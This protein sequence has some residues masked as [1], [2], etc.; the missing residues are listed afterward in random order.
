MTALVVDPITSSIVYA[1]TGSGVFKT[2]DGALSWA[3]ISKGLPSQITSLAVDPQHP[4]TVYF[5]ASGDYFGSRDYRS[6]DGGRAWTQM[7]PIVTGS[8]FGFPIP[9]T[10]LT[11]DPRSSNTLYA[12]ASVPAYPTHPEIGGA[13]VIYKSLDAGQ[14]WQKV[15]EVQSGGIASVLVDR[16][17]SSIVY[18]LISYRIYKSVDAGVTWNPANPAGVTYVSSL[19]QS[20]AGP[21]L[22]YAATSGNGVY[23]SPDGG[24]TWEAVNNGLTGDALA[25]SSVAAAGVSIVYASTGAGVFRSDDGGSSWRLMSPDRRSVLTVD[26]VQTSTLYGFDNYLASTGIF[27]GVSKSTDSG[28]TWS[29][30]NAGLNALGFSA[31]VVDPSSPATIYAGAFRRVSKSIDRGATWETHELGPPGYLLYVTDLVVDPFNSQTIYAATTGGV[32]RSSDGGSQW[33]SISGNLIPGVD[34]YINSLAV[35]SRVPERLFAGTGYGKLM[36]TDDGGATWIAIGP[37]ASDDGNSVVALDPARPGLVYFGSGDGLF[38]SEDSGAT[39]QPTSIEDTV[40]ALAI[41]PTVSDRVY[42][43]SRS[44]LFRSDDAGLHWKSIS[45]MLTSSI[46]I[47]PSHPSEI[48]VSNLGVQRSL[49]GGGT[50]TTE[51]NGLAVGELMTGGVGD[52]AWD[53]PGTHLYGA[54]TGVFEFEPANVVTI[55]AVSSLHGAPPTYFHSDV[56]VFNTSFQEPTRVTAKYRCLASACPEQTRTFMVPPRALSSYDDIVV[57]LFQQPET[58]GAVELASDQPLIVTSRLYTPARPSPTL[59]MF[60]PGLRAE[61]G[62]PKS[63][64]TS[65]SHSSQ[66]ALGSRTNIGV[67]NPSESSQT[68]RL[69]FRDTAGTDFGQIERTVG[70]GQLI[71]MNDPEIFSQLG[72][73]FDVPDFSCLVEGAAEQ[74]LFTYAAVIDN[75]SQDP[76]FVVGRSA[77][78]F[79]TT[80]ATLPA[81][82]SLHGA[83]GTFFHSDVS[84]FNPSTT[85]NLSIAARYRCGLGACTV[86]EKAFA[87]G[88][89][90][91]RKFNDFVGEFLQVPE[92]GGAVVFEAFNPPLAGLVVTSRLFTPT[93][94]DPTV[95]MFVPGLTPGEATVDAVLTSLASSSIPGK[96]FRTNVGAFNSSDASQTLSFFL[97]DA[98]GTALG[99]TSRVLPAGGAVQVNDIFRAVGA[100]GEIA[101]AYCL[102]RGDGQSPFFAYAAIIDNQTQD[103]IFVP[104]QSDLEVPRPPE[105]TH[106]D[107]SE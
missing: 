94:P 73:A 74:S 16:A 27:D 62:F 77:G 72:I 98:S 102:V 80:S 39:W 54:G 33:V 3:A 68:V 14:S 89:L 75:Q 22:L 88:P 13:A 107:R 17:S 93:R 50:W 26:P 45:A 70:P 65:L 47:R 99:R 41:D 36:R 105:L 79:T 48:R 69:S 23:R 86:S 11:V 57:T 28:A 87:V 66:Q 100:A 24:T 63:V 5:S 58:G 43:S 9:I 38:R 64:L 60:V 71:Q 59:G 49:D 8:A 4:S 40:L 52:L 96:G 97:Y 30:V 51:S 12:G 6:V 34:T 81:A 55:P 21:T 82:A 2:T 106:P 56:A 76:I 31:I 101:R 103:P 84:I 78:G 95:G 18:A 10:A 1:G 46:S 7:T 53:P 20:V 91:T 61:Q 104:G 15:F 32:Y 42:A 37:S 92:S 90:Q 19:T 35:D 44:G 67:Y 83:G 25:V 29:F 85:S